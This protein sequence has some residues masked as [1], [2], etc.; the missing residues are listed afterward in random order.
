M[1]RG[2][3]TTFILFT[4]AM[5]PLL[6]MA[7]EHTTEDRIRVTGQGHVDAVP[8]LATLRVSI[9]AVAPSVEEAKDEVD[10]RYEAAVEAITGVGIPEQDIDGAAVR[11]QKE[12]EWSNNRRLYKGERMTRVLNIKVRDTGLYGQTLEALVGAGISAVDQTSMGFSD[13]NAPRQAAL[14]IAADNA[15]ANAEFLAKRLGRRLGKVV[16]ITDQS[17]PGPGP[18][19][20]QPR[21]MMAAEAAADTAPPREM[22]G[23]RRVTASIVVEFELN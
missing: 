20:M 23:T 1:I 13:E 14:G 10:G 15:R 22:I 19:P 16:M 21:M 9:S 11:V 5:A 18:V 2:L 6:S 4:G 17:G 12:Y 8:D 7:Q 3:L